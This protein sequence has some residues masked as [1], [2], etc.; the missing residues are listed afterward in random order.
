MGSTL[1]MRISIEIEK[2][3]C[4]FKLLRLQRWTADEVDEAVLTT[5]KVTECLYT[6]TP[7]RTKPMMLLFVLAPTRLVAIK[8]DPS[9]SPVLD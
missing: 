3:D 2:P 5:A 1:S 6:L 9:K 4:V 8:A 7:T